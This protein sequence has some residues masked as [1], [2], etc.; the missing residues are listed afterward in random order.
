MDFIAVTQAGKGSVEEG[1]GSR[2]VIVEDYER[3]QC[4][5]RCHCYFVVLGRGGGQLN[6]EGGQNPTYRYGFVR[7]L[8]SP[9][10]VFATLLPS[11]GLSPRRSS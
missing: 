3:G 4:F 2:E 11:N 8:R 1:W 5:M 9:K 6:A 7:M 10:Y